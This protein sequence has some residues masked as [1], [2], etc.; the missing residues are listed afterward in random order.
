MKSIKGECERLKSG[1][2][3]IGETISGKEFEITLQIKSTEEFGRLSK[4]TLYRGDLSEKVEKIELEIDLES[5]KDYYTHLS[6]HSIKATNSDCYLRLEAK[7]QRDEFVY[8][9]ITNPIWINSHPV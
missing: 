8:R 2:A 1:I 9:C 5:T 3:N 7:S 4:A 6:K